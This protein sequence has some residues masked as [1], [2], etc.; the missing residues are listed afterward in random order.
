MALVVN[1]LPRV[2]KVSSAAGC[3]LTATSIKGLTPGELEA[4]ANKE[5][6]L[7]RVVLNAAEAKML[8]VQEHGLAT[9]LRSSI[10]NIKPALS[11]TKIDEQSIVLPY[12]QR[13]QRSFI[14]AQYF[15]IEAGVADPDAGTTVGGVA[16][17]ASAWL[18]T[19]NLGSSWL[20]TD[21]ENIERYFKP[22][23]SL[24][25]LT[26]DDTTAKN[27]KTLVFKIVRASNADAGGV[28]KATV[29]VEP[30]VA[31]D[32]WAGY[33]AGQ[34]A[35]YQPTFGVAQTGANSVSDREA[36]C[37]NSPADI[38]RK[39]IV[40][41]LQTSRFS[42][43]IDEAYQ[44]TLDQIMKGKVN[45]FMQGFQ[46][47]SIADQNKRA[48]QLEEEEWLRSVFFGQAINDKQTVEGYQN[49]PTVY[50]IED[51][52][53]PLEYK[54]NALGIFTFLTDCNRVMDLNGNDLD[55][56]VIF[57]Q[58]YLLK[59]HRE[60]DGDRVSVIDS[61]TDRL[62]AN[63]ILD[64]MTKYYKAKYGFELQ[65]VAKVGEKIT[66]E[67]Y[68]LFNYN[69]YDV[70]EQSVQWAVFHDTFFDDMLDAFPAT[71]GAGIDFK[72]RGRQL[73]FLDWSD[74]SVGI[75]GTKSVKRKQPHVESNALYKCVITPNVKEYNLRSTKWTVMVDRPH[76]H[77]IIHNF[78]GNCP[79]IQVTGCS[80]PNP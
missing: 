8:G 58:L 35:A 4:L 68:V 2:V 65:R 70:P 63:R 44:K 31:S 74:I 7:A 15:T 14:N 62:T 29:T 33:S 59:R 49:L 79:L 18:L 77:L 9:L 60:S 11:Q 13:T 48:A 71:V 32:T 17:P 56:D 30:N 38:S 22:G 73:W 1:C 53:C 39:I 54:A 25:V 61:M 26:W 66:H 27:A 24:I 47:N 67:G 28:K 69:I 5:I 50:D 46:F 41:W 78:S 19:L 42:R 52:A 34:K 37:H 40:N 3:T 12:I 36:W 43:Q 51:G 64:A 80:V 45:A 6:D 21:I 75:A 16:V 57:A 20:K 23:N 72:A 10:K 76:R 55:L